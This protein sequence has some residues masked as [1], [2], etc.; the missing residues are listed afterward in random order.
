M[1][2]VYMESQSR[3]RPVVEAPSCSIRLGIDVDF[4]DE[5]PTLYESWG[6]LS[7]NGQ[8][9]KKGHRHLDTEH[10]HEVMDEDELNISSQ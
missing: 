4:G 3:G 6:I 5:S 9:V 1:G 7:L 8:E 10:E 2:T